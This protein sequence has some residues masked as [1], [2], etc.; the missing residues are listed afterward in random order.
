MQKK[1]RIMAK[2]LAGLMVGT[3][4]YGA[5][6]TPA[7]ADEMINDDLV[8]TGGR[9]GRDISLTV[10]KGGATI[11]GGLTVDGTNVMYAIGTE[12]WTRATADAALG[13][14]LTTAEGKIA[15]E[16]DNREKK[17]TEL[18]KAIKDEA[19]RAKAAE[20]DLDKAIKDEADRA[21]A[22]EAKL[23]KAIND[24]ADRAKAAEADL[25]KAIKDEARIREAADN[26]LSRRIDDTNGRLDKVG[27]GAAALAALH[28][29]DYDSENKLSFAAGVGNYAGATS[30]AVGAFYRPNEDVMFSIGGTAGNGEN[31][32]NAGVSF[33]IGKGS[34]GLA[35]MNKADLVREVTMLKEGNN[36]LKG[37]NRELRH[38]INN[39]KAENQKLQD[40]IARLEE[41]VMKLAAQ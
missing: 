35:K 18:A 23:D 37:E 28:P 27:A 36:A 41:M 9:D 19:D 26:A 5:D 11:N 39:A 8:I 29:L 13:G 15:A 10:S 38:E 34:S 16:A 32:V 25:D 14:R 12:A 2:I 20:A 7:H 1:Q 21:K 17:D 40:R 24:E 3:L 6:M 30:A 33:A 4:A 22:E 31:M